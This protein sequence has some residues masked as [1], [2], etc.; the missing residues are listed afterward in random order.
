MLAG[1]TGSQQ[2]TYLMMVGKHLRVVLAT[3]HVPLAQVPRLITRELIT[4][5]IGKTDRALKDRFQIAKPRLAI[6]GL[7]PHA[8]ESGLFGLEE[9]HHF[10]PAIRE[11]Q[12]RG[13]DIRGPLPGDTVFYQAVQGEFDV[14]ISLYHDQGLIP[15]K[16]LHFDDAVNMTLGLPFIRTSV[17]HGVA[18]DIAWNNQ[19]NPASMVAAGRLAA[20]LVKG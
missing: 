2:K 3:L 7:N 12:E 4:D 18:F 19:A 14:V 8:G 9:E 6:A 15:I 20:Q 17:D 11:A 13:I 10:A 1:L 5:C 16:L